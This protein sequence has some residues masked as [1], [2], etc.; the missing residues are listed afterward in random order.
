LKS[1]PKIINGNL[2]IETAEDESEEVDQKN[3]DLIYFCYDEEFT[4]KEKT[5]ST[6]K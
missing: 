2:N 3:E 6:T 1:Q 4:R 5:Q